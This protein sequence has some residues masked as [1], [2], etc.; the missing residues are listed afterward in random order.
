M[1]LFKPEHVPLIKN[2]TKTQ[3]R[4]AWKK[5][6]VTVGST[7]LAKTQMLS[8][9]FFAKLRIK[10]VWQ[11]YLTDISEAD[12]KAEG[13]YTIPEYWDKFYE[14]NPPSIE[15]PFLWCVEFEVIHEENILKY[16]KVRESVVSRGNVTQKDV[17]S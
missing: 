5:C 17:K 3:T 13:G 6:R 12:A 14:I 16:M 11:E 15:N 9:E 8:K 2:G 1:I 4:R 7:Q 10:R